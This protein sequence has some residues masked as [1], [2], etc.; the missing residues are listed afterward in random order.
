MAQWSAASA[1]REEDHEA[2]NTHALKT[3][4]IA[5]IPSRHQPEFMT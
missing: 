3:G 4:C 2:Q 5:R 1:S